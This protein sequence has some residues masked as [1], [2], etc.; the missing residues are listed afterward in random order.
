MHTGL[1]DA[2]ANKGHWSYESGSVLYVMKNERE[3]RRLMLLRREIEAYDCD[4]LTVQEVK[5]LEKGE[6]HGFIWSGEDEHHQ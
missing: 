2:R 3:S 4:I 6:L 1:V 5:W